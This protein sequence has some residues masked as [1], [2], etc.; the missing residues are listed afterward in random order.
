MSDPRLTARERLKKRRD[1]DRVFAEG[2]HC[3][4]G[5][6]RVAA[7]PNDLGH[8]RLGVGVSTK[9]CNAVG[10]NRLKRITREAFRLNK[11]ALPAGLDIFVTHTTADATFEQVQASLLEATEALRDQRA[12]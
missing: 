6:L 4:S 1:I 2:R 3:S 11:D 9:V 7:A 8:S 10:R 5:T 12:E